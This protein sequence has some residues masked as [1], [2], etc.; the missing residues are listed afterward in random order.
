MLMSFPPGTEMF[1]FPGFASAAYGFSGGSSLAGGGCPIRRSSDHS[2]LAAPQGFSQRATSFIASWRQGIHQ[3]PLLSSAP[4]SD[5][6][7]MTPPSLRP[8]GD[9]ARRRT[10]PTKSRG[11]GG[12]RRE[13]F[14]RQ[15][16]T[17]SAGRSVAPKPTSGKHTHAKHAP[18]RRRKK[19]AG[20]HDLPAPAAPR[21]MAGSLL[22]CPHDGHLVTTSRCP[23]NMRLP[24]PNGPAARQRGTRFGRP[25]QARATT[26]APPRTGKRGL[27]GLGRLER[28]TSRL[29]GVRSN[30]LSYRPER[31][32]AGPRQR[33]AGQG[34]PMTSHPRTSGPTVVCEGTCRRR[35]AI[36]TPG[37]ER[38]SPHGPTCMPRACPRRWGP[39]EV[40]Q[41]RQT[42]ASAADADFMGCL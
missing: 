25:G 24:R 37:D 22:P 21:R 6:H 4:T 5:N 38:T 36:L 27:V 2:L 23:R 16:Q 18:C 14:Q 30:Q 29:S 34:E 32:P 28:P 39:R 42:T 15:L 41:P 11:C 12:R 8:G 33:A 31:H 3:M 19:R 40:V 13:R 1:Q 9:P 26:A 35:R 10:A 20:T 17:T 7:T